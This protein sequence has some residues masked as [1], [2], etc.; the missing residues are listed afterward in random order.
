MKKSSKGVWVGQGILL[1]SL[2][3]LLFRVAHDKKRIPFDRSIWL[4]PQTSR[5]ERWKMARDLQRRYLKPGLHEI[6]INY[7]LGKPDR[8]W[9]VQDASEHGFTY[10]LGR[11]HFGIF[12][13]ER[14]LAV[15][16]NPQGRVMDARIYPLTQRGDSG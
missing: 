15:R 3:C 8:Q 4:S 7:L 14:F 16:F 1:V 10:A 11:P 5:E 13:E 6:Q 9:M 12:G 2:S